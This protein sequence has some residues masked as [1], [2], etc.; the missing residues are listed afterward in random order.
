VRTVEISNVRRRLHDASV[1]TAIVTVLAVV[2]GGLLTYVAQR[3]LGKED[4]ERERKRA[5]VVTAK[6]M[7][8]AKRL[9]L[10][11]LY[12]IALQA[13]LLAKAGVHPVE[14]A[15]QFGDA[16]LPTDAWDSEKRTLA[17]N[18]P[19]ET[20]YAV[21]AIMQSIPS[22]RMQVF[23]GSPGGPLPSRALT[24]LKETAEIALAAYQE[25]GGKP[26]PPLP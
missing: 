2:V 4:A 15:D 12:T 25:L 22:V 3:Q 7:R 5:E 20:W 6:E 14:S 26:G 16:V 13:H 9:L 18:F 11:E 8:V 24:S 19:D 10:D 1:L 23:H 21:A 17:E